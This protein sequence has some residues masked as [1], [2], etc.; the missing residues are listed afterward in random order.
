MRLFGID[1]ETY[2]DKDYTLSKMTTE[3]YVRDPRFETIGVA[4]TEP[5]A[6]TR[7]WLEDAQFRAWV[8]LYRAGRFGR[9]SVF[10]HHAHFDG[11]IASHH[12]GFAPDFWYDT[13]SLANAIHG[14]GVA[15]SLEKLAERY[16]VGHKG[17]EVHTYRYMRRA[18]F[19]Q[20]QWLDYGRYSLNDADLTWYILQCMLRE[21]PQACLR[22][23][24]ELM[25][26]QIRCFTEPVLRLD[27]ERMTEYLH[28]ERTRKAELLARTG[29]DK[30]VF[31]SNPKFAELLLDFG[32]E[33]E[34]KLSPAALKN[35]E[36]KWTYAFAK[37]DSFMKGLLEHE[38]PDVRALAECR[39]GVKSTTNETRT[40]RLINAASR[41]PLPVYYRY[42]AA[43]TYRNG[44]ADKTNFMNLER[45]NK[46]K[47]RRGTIRKSLQAPDGSLLGVFDS[48]QIEARVLAG[49]AGETWLIDAFAQGRDIYSEFASDVW[50]RM[51][52]R[53]KNPEDE[54]PG[55]VG[56]VCIAEGQ[57]VLTDVGLVPIE[58]VRLEHRVWDGVEWV[59]HTGVV[60][61]G[62]KDVITIEGLTATPDHEVWTS[63]G[64]KVQLGSYEGSLGEEAPLAIGEIEGAPVR[65]CGGDRS[66]RA[67]SRRSDGSLSVHRMW[68]GEAHQRTEF[69]ERQEQRM[70]ELL[71]DYVEVRGG[72]RPEI[73]R[74]RVSVQE[75]EERSV[76]ELRRTRHQV[77]FQE[78]ET[79]HSVGRAISTSHGLS[80]GGDR[81]T[82]Q[83]RSLRTW[84]S[85]V[86]FAQGA[87][88]EP[89]VHT[90]G[91]VQRGEAGSDARRLP[92]DPRDRPRGSVCGEYSAAAGSGGAVSRT[93]NNE[94]LQRGQRQTKR[95]YDITNAGP[96]RRF[97]VS[98]VIVS[99]CILGLGYQ[100]GSPKLA[101]TFLAGALGGEPVVFDKAMM[102]SM[103]IDASRF[104]NNPRK[105][106]AA[107]EM[108]C[109]L[110]TNDRLIHCIV[111]DAIHQRYRAKNKKIVAFWDFAERMLQM[112]VECPEGTEI[113]LNTAI[114]LSVVYHGIKLPNGMVLRYPGLEGKLEGT[115]VR[116]SFNGG[117]SGR[118]REH[119]YG[120]KITENIVQA[121]ARIIVMYQ[122]LAIRR[123]YGYKLVLTTYDEGVML[124]PEAEA[125]IAYQRCLKEFQT[126]PWWA[127]WLPIAAEG[128]FGKVYGDIK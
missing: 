40:E 124:F 28:Y 58:S 93:D 71:A 13:L 95:V 52:D 34:M 104:L 77:L 19:T 89:S 100:M 128:G 64:R 1:F 81:P 50:N 51:I 8:Q 101:S 63:D 90:A 67:C 23:E 41:G 106:A 120:G 107:H 111:S 16:G 117:D 79:V 20:E 9:A 59:A 82:E 84:E 7:V 69:D 11:L 66:G 39:V 68:N 10:A 72:T 56:K 57:L 46:K 116:Y 21:F 15:K 17:R 125:A 12:Y 25:D 92:F 33:P 14:P 118:Q 94:V 22:E 29:E 83:R 49:L 32:I 4:V 35:G 110:S 37:S 61:Q 26:M 76:E 45:T 2:W 74:D 31:A 86:G 24:L 127:P 96:R 105:V 112:M 115:K 119:T 18:Q 108:S 73:R 60:Y 88:S 43:H 98:G 65:F 85:S 87:D 121:L 75:P 99:N 27:V 102:D 38:D 78:P 80:R 113:P 44:G 47:P 5:L 91:V 36:E 53:K 30:S 62:V 42:A 122:I 97:T 54:L 109:R 123:N 126:P 3:A 114:P 55:F 70:P 48:S 6:G 103:G